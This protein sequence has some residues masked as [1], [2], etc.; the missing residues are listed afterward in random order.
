MFIHLFLPLFI[1]QHTMKVTKFVPQDMKHLR[2]EGRIPEV[3]L[4]AAV[5]F[6]LSG[7]SNR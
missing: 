7:N 4:G 1:I 5:A 6:H 2:S 3:L